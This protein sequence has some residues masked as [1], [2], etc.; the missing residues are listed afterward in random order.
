MFPI[1]RRHWTLWAA[2]L[3]VGAFALRAS[4]WTPFSWAELVAVTGSLTLCLDRRLGREGV[5]AVGLPAIALL[6]FLDAEPVRVGR[7]L[8][9][10]LVFTGAVLFASRAVDDQRD[11]ETIAGQLALGVD[12]DR[13]IAILREAA[14]AEIARARRH[15]KRFVLLSFAPAPDARPA[16]SGAPSAA[17]GA[18]SAARS[19]S[20]ATRQLLDARGVLEL[21]EWLRRSLHRYATVAVTPQR[22][23]GL[24]PEIEREETPALVRRLVQGAESALGLQVEVG[25][26]AFPD[27]ALDFEGLVEAADAGRGRPLLEPV[28]GGGAGDIEARASLREEQA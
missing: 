20:E 12:A 10:W 27:G 13:A 8:A 9:D 14:E 25:V 16:A 7:L 23:L 5:L 1:L 22:V 21:G 3:L 18:P 28:P 6:A 24:V 26:A 19:A 2:W 4:P 17:S 15:E 11:L